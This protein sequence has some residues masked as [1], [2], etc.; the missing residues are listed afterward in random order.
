MAPPLAPGAPSSTAPRFYVTP[1]HRFNAGAVVLAVLLA[2]ACLSA[3][4]FALRH[5]RHAHGFAFGPGGSPS[6]GFGFGGGSGDADDDDPSQVDTIYLGGPDQAPV[7]TRPAAHPST[8]H[9]F[10]VVHL[11]RSGGEVGQIPDSPAG[12]LLFD[13]LASFNNRDASAAAHALPGT[14]AARA[15]EAQLALRK[16][17]G[18]FTLLAAKE[19]APGLLVF[20]LHDETP[21]ETEFLGT[22]QVQA[23]SNPAAIQSFSLRSVPPSQGSQPASH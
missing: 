23:N 12:H 6:G 5:T 7:T 13:W 8:V 4:V 2:T 3:V 9:P 15:A 17:T 21:A 20:R 22:L 19:V 11:P 16:Q 14:T 1:R 18:G 10:V